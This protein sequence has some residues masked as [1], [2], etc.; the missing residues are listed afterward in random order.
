MK[1]NRVAILAGGKGSR[2]RERAGS[3]PKPM[4]PICGRPVLEHQILLAR[5]HGFT[6]IA[7]L[8][9]F[10]HQAVQAYFGTGEKLGVTLDYHVEPVPRGTAGAL[11][12]AL[13]RLADNFLVLYGDTYFDVDLTRFWAAHISG[14]AD[15]TLF[16]HP[17]D[18]P[19]DSDLVEVDERGRIVAVRPYPHPAGSAYANLVNAALY[20]M[21]S[22]GLAAVLPAEGSQD[23]AKHSFSAMLA[24]GLTLKGYQSPEY[25]KDMGTPERLDRVGE[26]IRSGLPD[27]LSTR[28]RRRAVFLDRD[29]TLNI[30]KGLIRR[31][32]DLV[33]LPGV[34]TAVRK[35][36][37]FGMLAVGITNQPVV[38]RGE[39]DF[40]GLAAIHGR[41]DFALGEEGAY[42]DRIYFCPH[43]PDGGF[44]GETV[45]LKG[46]CSCRK[47]KAGM[48]D[49][50][51][52]TLFVD[53]AASWMIGDATSDIRA[54]R[55][56]GVRTVLVRTGHGGSD[57]IYNDPPDYV[58][59]DLAEAVSWILDGR[60]AMIQQLRPVL[61]A[62]VD[63][64]L[65]LIGGAARA[66]KTFVGRLL[67]EMLE[68]V[69][70]TVVRT[71]IGAEVI[72]MLASGGSEVVVFEGDDILQDP[73]WCRLAPVRLLVVADEQIRQ[74]RLASYGRVAKKP[75]SADDGRN[76]THIISG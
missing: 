70:R 45:A 7:L 75:A 60:P 69:G 23:L 19:V 64:R 33:L 13:P 4:V 61:A 71:M 65:V 73:R 43:H 41:L 52:E 38:A 31:P 53:R 56:A 3:L 66:G 36:N 16:V 67:G 25:I 37:R 51:V 42:L 10:E 54:G 44:P 34:G 21:R 30:E 11:R 22:D 55:T 1:L 28:Q 5:A 12:D 9:H 39:V 50:A 17:N 49:V 48:I 27:R 15:A 8:V 35:L 62:A 57:R 2:L 46:E 18:H 32:D 6:E 47:P 40:A 68:A 59:N 20:A 72:A 14:R 74:Q 58:T 29:G 26:D 63:A 24:A 76:A